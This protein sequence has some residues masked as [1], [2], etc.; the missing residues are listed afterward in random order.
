MEWK[1]DS[2]QLLAGSISRADSTEALV[3]PLLALLERLSGLESTYLT[4]VDEAAGLQHI[5]FARNAGSLSIPEGLS[6]PWDD[7]LCKRALDEGRAYTADVAG[8]WGDSVAAAELGLKTYLSVPVC[9]G[10]GALYGTLCGASAESR[11]VQDGITEIMTLFARLIAQQ[12]ER[13]AEARR[14]LLRAEQAERRLHSMAL[15]ATLGGYCLRADALAPALAEAARL[16]LERGTW[17]QAWPFEMAGAAPIALGTE[18]PTRSGHIARVLASMGFHGRQAPAADTPCLHLLRS[19][20]ADGALRQ[21]RAGHGLPMDGDAGLLAVLLDDGLAAGVVLL[22]EGRVKPAEDTVLSALSNQLSLLGARLANL[23]QLEAA[24]DELARHAH[25][26][27]LTGLPNRRHLEDAYRRLQAHATRSGQ[28]LMLAFMDLD[29]FKAINDTHGH[30]VGD[31]FL[32]TIATR[33]RNTAR[34]EDLIAR[35]GG[36]EFVVAG[37]K[38]GQK[39][40]ENAIAHFIDRL[41]QACIGTIHAGHV[42]IEYAG[43]SI[44][45]V[46]AND[47]ETLEALLERADRAMYEDKRRRRGST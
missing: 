3:R 41:R 19:A 46:F 23:R 34:T 40:V 6:V 30:D 24:N 12:I 47:G 26:D 16:L 20:E 10:D 7:T 9:L 42:R 37:I 17:V 36:D 32:R 44:G 43:P 5:L 14:S 35:I 29:G 8:C 4:A 39:T 45:G 31:A 25:Q 13:D 1:G 22:A 21:A 28:P 18:D 2:L 11:Q 27:P 15:I 38:H 33:L